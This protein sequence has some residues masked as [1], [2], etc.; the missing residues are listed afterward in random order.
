[1][2]TRKMHESPRLTIINLK[3]AARKI[4]PCGLPCPDPQDGRSA[5]L[6]SRLSER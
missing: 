3:R 1:M 5:V 2:E 6:R 4:N